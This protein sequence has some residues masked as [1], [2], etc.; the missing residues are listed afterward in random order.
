MPESPANGV[1]T[2]LA[3]PISNSAGTCHLASTAGWAN[4]QY[5]CLIT[6]GV[7]FEVVEATG[8]SGSILSINRAAET[9]GGSAT[10]YAF[11]TG[12]TITITTTVQSVIDLILEYGGGGSGVSAIFAVGADTQYENVTS[13]ASFPY[14]PTGFTTGEMFLT[15]TSVPTLVA[16]G[17]DVIQAGSV[18]TVI[19]GLDTTNDSYDLNAVLTIG[20]ADGS[21]LLNVQA[22]GTIPQ[23]GPG[24][25]GSVDWTTGSASQLVGTDLTWTAGTESVTSTAGGVFVVRMSAV[26]TWS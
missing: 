21:Q 23:S 9:W 3:A 11:N 13:V 2:T 20:S 18:Y 14:D 17:G 22:V 7:H 24:T 4:A 5:H 19:Y 1:T 12:S 10:A 16:P 15:A 26:G 25:S 6:D 8:L